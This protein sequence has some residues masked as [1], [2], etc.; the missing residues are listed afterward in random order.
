MW[1]VRRWRLAADM[2]LQ[3]EQ[4]TLLAGMETFKKKDLTVSEIPK[5]SAK[6][7]SP[8]GLRREGLGLVVRG[9]GSDDLVA[10]LVD[11]SGLRG[12]EL[13]LLFRLLLNLGD[14]LTLL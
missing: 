6:P 11:G 4:D 7:D 5:S 13:R 8:F 10:V 14:L 2:A 1:L 12:C 3:N 9:R